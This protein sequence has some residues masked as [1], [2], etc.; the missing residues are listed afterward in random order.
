M[1]II[2]FSVNGIRK[3]EGVCISLFDDLPLIRELREQS[4]TPF[5]GKMSVSPSGHATVVE[6]L[7]R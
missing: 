1:L 4:Q 2:F 7:F 6:V 3:S 5:H